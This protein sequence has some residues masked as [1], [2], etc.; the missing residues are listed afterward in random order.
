MLLYDFAIIGGGPTGYSAA[1]YA[2]RL[3][4]KTLILSGNPGGLIVT[5]QIVENYPGFKRITGVELFQKVQDHAK[6]YSITEFFEHAQDVARETQNFVIKTKKTH[7]HAKTVLFATGAKYRKLSAIGAEKFENKGVHYCALCDGFAY[8][9]KIVAVVG[10]SDSAA[11]EALELSELAQKVYIIHRGENIKPEP[12][13]KDRIMRSKKIEIITK[14]NV[15]EILGQDVVEAVKLDASYKEST[16]LP[17]SGIFIAI[18]HIPQSDLAQKLGVAVNEKKEIII[19]RYARTNIPGVYAAGDV[20][21]TAFKQMI[22]GC[23]EGVFA[24]YQAF[25]HIHTP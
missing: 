18:G 4:L 2:G 24:A 22:I 12:I 8:K 13:N 11:K 20:A 5:A 3:N 14:T 7:Y 21:D 15:V 17:L 25:N 1:M 19:D 9:D 16:T 23:A 6:E 10:G